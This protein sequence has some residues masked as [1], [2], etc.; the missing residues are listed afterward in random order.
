MKRVWAFC[1]LDKGSLW[2]E[3]KLKWI[4]DSHQAIWGHDQG[5]MRMKWDH[6]LEKDHNSFK[7]CEVTVRT[8]Q[9]LHIVEA[10][11]LKVYTQELEAE[12]HGWMKALVLSIKYTTPV[13]ISYTK[14][15]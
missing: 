14:R 3:A 2:S 11:N 15:E 9:L 10:T 5:I 7:M 12:A 13:I 8:D 6:A 4:G 1:S